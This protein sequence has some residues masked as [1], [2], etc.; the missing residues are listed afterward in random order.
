V[1]LRLLHDTDADLAREA[2]QDIHVW[3]NFSAATVRQPADEQRQALV[4]LLEKAVDAI[5]A[6]SI[7]RIR[8]VLANTRGCEVGA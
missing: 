7:D 2:R 5:D 1:D 3:W 8:F 4:S 6:P